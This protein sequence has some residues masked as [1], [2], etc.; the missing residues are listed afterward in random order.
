[1][2][3]RKQENNFQEREK[4]STTLDK[5]TK[6]AESLL[7]NPRKRNKLL[8]A[9]ASM[10]SSGN[11]AL[12]ASGITGKIKTLVRMVRCT[13]SREYLDIPWQSIVFIT[14][15]LIYFVS[16]FDA[17][18]DFLPLIGFVDDA[19]IISAVFAS[20]SKDVEKFI[21]WE[22]AKSASDTAII[23]SAEPE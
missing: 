9:A 12:Q 5:A 6:K 2:N 22:A 21:A 19:A 16:P 23:S 10:V 4:M 15:A 20:I 18:S 14:A 7:K 11:Y 3:T 8:D 13:A 17:I 1:L